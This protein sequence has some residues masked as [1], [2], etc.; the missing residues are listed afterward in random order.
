[1]WR[2]KANLVTALRNQLQKTIVFEMAYL[3][4]VTWLR[5][6][7]RRFATNLAIIAKRRANSTPMRGNVAKKQQKDMVLNGV[8]KQ[9]IALGKKVVEATAGKIAARISP[10]SRYLLLLRMN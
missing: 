9:S 7:M 4:V 3:V 5:D 1:M 8:G 6:G 10:S 2:N